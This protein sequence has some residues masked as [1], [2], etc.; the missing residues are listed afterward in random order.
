MRA[1]TRAS[2]SAGMVVTVLALAPIALADVVVGSSPTTLTLNPAIFNNSQQAR[3]RVIIEH[4]ADSSRNGVRVRQIGFGDPTISTSDEDCTQNVF[5]NDVV[6]NRV[7]GSIIINA[8]DAADEV[9]VGG[10]NVGC[11]ATSGTPVLLN[12]NGGDDIVRAATGCGQTSP[13]GINRLHPIF[14]AVGGGGDDTIRGGALNDRLDG[15]DGDDELHG[16]AG[17]DTLS[18]GG[19]SDILDGGAGT[20]T[21]T[22]AGPTAV[23]V[24]LDGAAND[25]APGEADKVE[26]VESVV[27]SSAGDE[28]TGSAGAETL[29]GGGGADEIVGG[30]GADTL[31]GEA[32]NDL[33]D[34]RD[35]VADSVK[36][37]SGSDEV[38][39]DLLDVVEKVPLLTLGQ[40]DTGCETVGRF[41]VDDGPP[42]RAVGRRIVITKARRL[43]ITVLCP[44]RARVAC[45]G[46]LRVLGAGRSSR[47]LATARYSIRLGRSRRVHLRLTARRAARLRA[48]RIAI[49]VTREQGV[50][51][52]GPR[53]AS[54]T[55]RVG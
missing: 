18:G 39:A 38:I 10:S 34:A 7:P 3:A 43:S 27:G 49:V 12:L 21:V 32:G 2:A 28:L 24:T 20:D 46:R 8:A 5:L 31:R 41:A 15:D 19:D 40:F 9:V 14:E 33:I 52:K 13:S 53:S 26:S 55:L 4:F 30:D 22:Y 47:T 50:S 25:G 48:K 51:K 45:R 37:G 17:N 42:G 1:W 16:G 35:G 23:K 11:E 44:R 54:H 36:C 29:A 6:C